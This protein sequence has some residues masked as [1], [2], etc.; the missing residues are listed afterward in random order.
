V[1]AELHDLPFA[2]RD[3]DDERAVQVLVTTRAQHAERLQPA[4]ERCARASVRPREAIAECP[5]R[6]AELEVID[7]GAVAQTASLEEAKRLLVRKEHLVVVRR[8]L[9]EERRLVVFRVEL[10]SEKV[11]R[12]GGRRCRLGG[13]RLHAGTKELLGMP[14]GDADDPTDEIDY[15]ARQLA[16]RAPPAVVIGHDHEATA[17][18][19][20][21][22]PGE[23]AVLL[24]RQIQ[25][26]SLCDLDDRGRAFFDG[27]PRRHGESR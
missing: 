10:R 5:V 8:H 11:P 7:H 27:A 25:S 21:A 17:V 12:R 18:V 16:A 9:A 26:E 23:T 22:D 4:P 19:E 1:A 14:P 24:G 13:Q 2:V 3:R 15:R 6:E 20:G